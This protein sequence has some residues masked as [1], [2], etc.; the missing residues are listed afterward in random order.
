MAWQYLGE[1]EFAAQIADYSDPNG[2]FFYFAQLHGWFQQISEA[3][4]CF[5]LKSEENRDRLS[6]YDLRTAAYRFCRILGFT[7][8]YKLEDGT[9]LTD[10]LSFDKLKYRPQ[11]ISE[12][13][14]GSLAQWLAVF[15]HENPYQDFSETYS[16][17]RSLESWILL[18][19]ELDQHQLYYK[20]Y[21]NA[22]EETARKYNEVRRGYQLAKAKEH[23]WRIVFYSLCGIWLLLLCIFGVSGRDYLLHYSFFT[24]GVPLGGVTA[25]IVG[26]RAFFRGYGFVLSCLWGALGALSSLIPILTLKYVN[27]SMPSLFV[28]IIVV[29]TLIYMAICHFTDFR[30]DSKEDNQLI[31]EVLD[32]DIKSTLLEPLY[33]T[34]KQKT[35]KFKGSKFGMLDDVT[36]QVRSIS[37]ESVMHYVLWS[38]M[39]GVLVMEMIVY[40]PSLLNVSNPDLNN[41]RLSPTKVIQ[42]IQKDVE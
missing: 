32:D 13:N 23:S 16:Y 28:P 20:R 39:V 8:A 33:Y 22:K 29:F 1:K 35:Y 14:R 17:E 15:Y 11:L 6:A 21:G 40:S 38:M 42:Q 3:R 19:G 34:F 25:I 2:R 30:G 26:T 41:W 24:I 31:S 5:D 9:V 27:G 36:N 12:L 7:P 37:G 10:G 4:N 18:L